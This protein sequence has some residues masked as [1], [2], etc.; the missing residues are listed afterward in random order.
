V[1]AHDLL[2]RAGRRVEGIDGDLITEA[3]LAGDVAALQVFVAGGRRPGLGVAQLA[4]VLDPGVVVAG[5]VAAPSA[6][7]LLPLLRAYTK[8][9]GLPSRPP[10]RTC[11]SR[12][13]KP[14]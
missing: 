7:L 8:S 5:G 1:L 6:T 3:A 2:Q 4:A 12:P 14:E 9:P 13:P 11:S 10:S